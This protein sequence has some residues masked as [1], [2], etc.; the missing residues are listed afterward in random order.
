MSACSKGKGVRGSFKFIPE[1]TSGRQSVSVSVCDYGH[2]NFVR[3]FDAFKKNGIEK[4]KKMTERG[5]LFPSL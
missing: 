3:L 1:G 4:P 5:V 2:E